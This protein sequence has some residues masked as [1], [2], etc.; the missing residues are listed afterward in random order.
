MLISG[1]LFSL[2]LKTA[3]SG[4]SHVPGTI[5]SVAQ[6]GLPNP[7]K[8]WKTRADEEDSLIAAR[9]VGFVGKNLGEETVKKV[10]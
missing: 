7:A 1:V 5:D 6:G 4:E 3:S 2:V 9:V 10:I 8:E